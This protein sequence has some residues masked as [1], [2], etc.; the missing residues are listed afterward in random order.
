MAKHPFEHFNLDESLI[1]AVQD[2]NFEKPTEIQ[3]RIIPRIL[4]GTNLIGQS[5][6]GTGKSHSFLLPLMQ[7]IDV[8]VQEPQAIVVAPTRE[9]AQQLFQAASH[10]SQFK[11]DVSVKLFIGGTD[12]EKDKQR[13]NRQPQLIIGTPTRINDLAQ[14]GYLHA[15]LASNLIVDEADLMIDLGLIEDVDYI[16]ARLDD[17]AHIAVFSATI[18]KSL[19]PFLNKYLSQP[20]FVEVDSKSQN[21]KNIEFYLIPTKGTAKIDKTLSLI[22]MLNPYLCI[23]FCNSRENANELANSLNNEGIKVGMIHGG[24]TPRERKQQM[25][26]IRNLDFQYVIASD[27]ASRGIDIEGV[28]HVIN[29]DVPNDIDFFTHRVGRTGRGNYKGV[30]ITLYSPDEEHN[31][32]LIEDKGYHFENVDIK[33]GELKPIKAHDTRRTRQRKDDHLTNEVK[34]KEKL[35]QVIRKSLSKK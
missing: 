15:H 33:N 16:A 4:K 20:E 21:K 2:L 24:L 5:Q 14:G 8:D 35:N 32:S 27:L 1:K 18:P 10:L 6:T 29:F 9:L 23:I 19:Q 13:C 17:E 3:N 22:D 30:A 34:R 11:Q 31:I 12:I 25:K 7:K 26:R 28:S